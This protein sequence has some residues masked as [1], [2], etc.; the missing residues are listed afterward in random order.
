[1]NPLFEEAV[2][3]YIDTNGKTR[4][5]NYSINGG[6]ISLC[7]SP[8]PPLRV[9]SINLKDTKTV[10]VAV[11]VEF[12][13]IKSLQVVEQDGNKENGIK[14]IWVETKE[15]NSGIYYGY[16]PITPTKKTIG[17]VPF[18]K[19]NDPIRTNVTQQ[20]ELAAFRKNRKIAEI[21]KQYTLFTY[22][23]HPEDF[24]E[25]Y[26]W[27]DPDH[28]YDVE[29]LNKRLYVEGNDV[30]YRDGYI[31]VPS[32]EVKN[33]LMSFLKVNLLNDTPGVMAMTNAKTIENYYQTIS[34]FRFQG[35]EQLIFVNRTGLKRW[36]YE[37]VAKNK[38][39]RVVSAFPIDN[40]KDPYYYKN[41]KIR[42][43][44]LMI[45]QNVNGGTL[46]RAIS[47]AYKWNT[48]RRN[49]GWDTAV[50]DIIDDISYVI[51]VETGEIERQKKKTNF[52]HIF[53][54]ENGEYA[55][56]LFFI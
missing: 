18:S 38:N 16:I 41:I 51:Y 52:T 3:Q 27:V 32:E 23:M 31:L 34:D 24:D 39:R 4:M 19:R 15:Q 55:A 10:S 9:P 6:Q 56:L 35:P 37:M 50:S 40:S 25:N 22:A 49:H 26:F 30:I 17:N 2:G 1:M 14:G 29:K 44:S 33:G 47:V 36:K 21:L 20:S 5:V 7:V 8:I 46:E 28:V 53:Q 45:V 54:Y 43:D 42:R 48:F 13:K 11:A 12:M